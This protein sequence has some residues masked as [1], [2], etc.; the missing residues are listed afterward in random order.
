MSD[1]RVDDG[2]A[3]AKPYFEAIVG[4]SVRDMSVKAGESTDEE[5]PEP[6]PTEKPPEPDPSEPPE[7]ENE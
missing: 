3:L 1:D 6:Q 4:V 5:E 2:F 7:A